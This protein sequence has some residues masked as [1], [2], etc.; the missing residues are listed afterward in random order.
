M[1]CLDN[2]KNIEGIFQLSGLNKETTTINKSAA[3][4]EGSGKVL[5]GVDSYIT[6][7]KRKSRSRAASTLEPHPKQAKKYQRQSKPFCNSCR[8]R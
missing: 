1:I 6:T 4:P 7:T 2:H 3:K 8:E 5:T